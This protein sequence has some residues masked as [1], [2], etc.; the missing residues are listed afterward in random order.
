MGAPPGEDTVDMKVDT[1]NIN[2]QIVGQMF[3]GQESQSDPLLAGLRN[4]AWLDA[5]NFPPLRYVVPG[6]IPEGLTLLI[7]APKIGKSWLALDIALAVA[8]GGRVLG[9]IA[10]GPARPVLLLALE[11]G[12]R[13][14]QDRI[15]TLIPGEPIPARLD[16]MTRIL[17]GMV[18]PTIEAWLAT[19]PADAEPLVLLDTLGK[20]VPPA[21]TGETTYQRDY[22]VA[23][24][25][26]L[27]CDDRPGM[28]LGVLHH[29]RKA[30]SDDFVDGVSGTNGLAGA[31]DTIVVISRPRNETQGLLQV[32]GRDVVEAEYAAT[33]EKGRWELMGNTL[34][35]AAGTAVTIHATANL[36]DRS[37]EILRF[38]AKHPEGV[39][40]GDVAKAVDLTPD[41]AGVYLTR[42]FNAAKLKK[43]ERGL[44]TPVISVISVMSERDTP[45][46]DDTNDINDT[47][48]RGCDVCGFPLHHALIAEGVSIHPNC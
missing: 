39:R 42:L 10:V 1:K 14:L 47:T 45:A 46:E 21:A 41:D 30:G 20:V 6:L 27:I 5:Q 28:S 25:L 12:D 19:V 11:D 33:V 48:S 23:G 13:R 38:V 15:R 31:A 44:Y 36:G 16:Y 3:G 34:D 43:P 9:H 40:R 22:K 26:K 4:G 2:P 24:R 32:T 18:V 29:D 8:C 35:E 17:P 37:A 7:G